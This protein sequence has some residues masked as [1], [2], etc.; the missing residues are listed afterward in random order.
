MSGWDPVLA[1]L[2]YIILGLIIDGS[3]HWPNVLQFGSA[4][5]SASRSSART[6][7]SGCFTATA[8]Q[9]VFD[10]RLYRL[11]VPHPA[12]L[13]WGLTITA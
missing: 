6:L 12:R 2:P 13:L 7:R 1:A 9:S 10:H 11:I 8:A 5:S 4:P 3:G